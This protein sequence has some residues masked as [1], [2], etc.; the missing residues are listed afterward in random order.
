MEREI[1]FRGRIAHGLDN[2]GRWVYWGVSGT[3]MI[4]V[5]DHDTIG[6]LTGLRDCNG[7]EVYEGDLVSVKGCRICEVVFHEPAGC[8]DLVVRNI[9]LSDPIGAV[10]PASWEYHTEVIGNIYENSDLQ[11]S[12]G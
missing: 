6:Q 4:D 3:G 2:A 1:K 5:I 7:V 11:A 12:Q 10:S 8:W 9:L